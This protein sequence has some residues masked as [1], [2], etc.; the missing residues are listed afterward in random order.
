MGKMKYNNVTPKQHA[1]SIITNEIEFAMLSV[2]DNPQNLPDAFKQRVIK[3]LAILKARLIIAA[4]LQ[5][6]E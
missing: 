5:K 4:K 1:Y 6:E 3:H 2:A